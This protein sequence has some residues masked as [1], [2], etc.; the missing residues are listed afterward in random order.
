MLCLTIRDRLMEGRMELISIFLFLLIRFRIMLELM[1][2][3][4]V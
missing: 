4:G 3:R 1:K 2:C